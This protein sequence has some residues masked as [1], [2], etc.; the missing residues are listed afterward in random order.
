MYRRKNK[1]WLKHM[2]FIILD[3]LCLQVCFALAYFSR[4][5]FD[6]IKNHASAS[7]CH[8]IAAFYTIVQ[9]AAIITKFIM[10]VKSYFV[11]ETANYSQI[12]YNYSHC[13]LSIS[14]V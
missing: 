3:L 4:H 13:N 2:D 11:N 9:S 7:S 6:A 12:L 5:G 14:V 1:G 10:I 8:I